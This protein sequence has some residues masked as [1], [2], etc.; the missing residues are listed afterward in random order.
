M[1]AQHQHL[2]DLWIDLLS[3]GPAEELWNRILKKARNAVGVARERERKQTPQRRNPNKEA[4]AGIVCEPA[5]GLPVETLMSQWE[6]VQSVARVLWKDGYVAV[7]ACHLQGEGQD[8][9]FI[10]GIWF[11]SLL[12]RSETRL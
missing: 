3:G 5:R 8:R 6:D 9:V 11:F 10:A 7:A 1:I 12:K 2:I 4:W